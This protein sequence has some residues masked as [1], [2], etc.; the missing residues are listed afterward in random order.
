MSSPYCHSLSAVVCCIVPRFDARRTTVV[1]AGGFVSIAFRR[2]PT[3]PPDANALPGWMCR[4]TSRNPNV[5]CLM[6]AAF[7]RGARSNPHW[8]AT[9]V[10]TVFNWLSAI[11]YEPTLCAH[12]VGDGPYHLGT[13]SRL[14]CR[15]S[16]MGTI[17][18]TTAAAERFRR[19][20]ITSL[21]KRQQPSTWWHPRRNILLG[22]LKRK[23]TACNIRVG[24]RLHGLG[25]RVA[26]LVGMTTF[27]WAVE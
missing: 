23:R 27:T 21:A 2:A 6:A 7:A 20:E 5:W 11:G 22:A 8:W 13:S 12:S 18:A 9:A 17:P 3:A 15:T 26:A 24:Y 25:R 1:V 10:A 4:R 16:F 14:C 19:A